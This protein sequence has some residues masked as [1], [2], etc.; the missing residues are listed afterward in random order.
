[1]E[2]SVRMVVMPMP[3][4][5]GTDSAG[6]N[7]DSQASTTN[8]V[9]GTG[10]KIMNISQ[11]R[12]LAW[13]GNNLYLFYTIPGYVGLHHVVAYLPHEVKLEQGFHLRGL[14]HNVHNNK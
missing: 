6:T 7:S 4:L 8:T 9:L 3:T 12:T 11:L 13:L 14:N 2:V 1:M 10:A 5:P